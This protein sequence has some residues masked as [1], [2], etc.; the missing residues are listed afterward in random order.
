[1][2]YGT[3]IEAGSAWRLAAGRVHGWHRAPGGATGWLA[4][5][6]GTGIAAGGSAGD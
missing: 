6:G 4:V 5:A 2:P 3:G 1:V